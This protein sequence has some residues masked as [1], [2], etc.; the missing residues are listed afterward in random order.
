MTTPV[1][2][3]WS[4]GK[5][6]AFALRRL[7]QDAR[8]R[9]IGLLTTLTEGYDR[10][11]MHG[12]RRDLLE[13]QAEALGLRVYPVWIPPGCVNPVYEAAMRR[14]IEEIKA[15][16]AEAVAHGDIYLEDVRAYR[17]KMLEDSGL[18]P[19]FPIWGGD[20]AQLAR[21]IISSGFR[22]TLGGC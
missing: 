13:A 11:S 4:G 20:T 21:T 12:V 7:Q 3:A 18:T 8:Y 14:A 10:I 22:A 5:D 17:E 16:G 9:V 2:M 1:V 15:D 6:S 19:L